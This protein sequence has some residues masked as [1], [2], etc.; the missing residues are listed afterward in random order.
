MIHENAF[1]SQPARVLDLPAVGTVPDLLTA[2]GIEPGLHPLAYVSL[3]GEPVAFEHGHRVRPKDGTQMDVVL[4]LAG[5]LQGL[6]MLVGN[7]TL[8][9]AFSLVANIGGALLGQYVG[10][11]GGALLGAGVSVGGVLAINALIPPPVEEFLNTASVTGSQS[12]MRVY[13]PVPVLFGESRL[14]PPLA[15]QAYTEVGDKNEQYLRLVYVLG[16][17][18]LHVE[19]FRIGDTPIKDYVGRGNVEGPFIEVTGGE[20]TRRTFLDEAPGWEILPPPTAFNLN[21]TVN[22]RSL[23]VALEHGDES[24]G[25]WYTQVAPA[26]QE[27]PEDA[28]YYENVRIGITSGERATGAE[29]AVDITFPNGLYWGDQDN[30]TPQTVTFEIQYR[31]AGSGDDDESGGWM[32]VTFT[33]EANL[34]L[35]NHAQQTPDQWPNW[36][37]ELTSR[38]EERLAAVQAIASVNRRA[39]SGWIATFKRSLLRA[40]D[41]ARDLR[42]RYEDED[43]EPAIQGL[44]NVLQNWFTESSTK[45]L[46][47]W[48]SRWAAFD[49]HVNW[50]ATVVESVNALTDVIAYLQQPGIDPIDLADYPMF[51]SFWLNRQNR[52]NQ[53]DLPEE[54]EFWV[55]DAY[56]GTVRRTVRWYVTPGQ[57]EVR[58]RRVTPDYDDDSPVVD[59]AQ[60]TALRSIRHI[61]PV[62]EDGLVIAHVRIKA[63][64]QL[65]GMVDRLNCLAR[66]YVPVWTDGASAYTDWP[67]SYAQARNPAWQYLSRICDPRLAKRPM[68]L[69]RVD[70]DAIKDWAAACVA[71]T[72]LGPSG[73]VCDLVIDR[74]STTF[75][76]LKTIASVGRAAF[77]MSDTGR[78]SVLR[79][80]AQTDVVQHFSPRNSWGFTSQKHFADETHGL[81]LRF[82]NSESDY[83]EDEI[84]VYN[85]K[86]D[87]TYWSEA[88]ATI[89]EEMQFPGYPTAKQA[90][91]D[92]RF[93]LGAFRLRPERFAFETDVEHLACGRGSLIRVAHDVPM[94]GLG[95]GRVKSVG[96]GALS[97]VLDEPMPMELAKNYAVRFRL[98]TSGAT[99]GDTIVCNVVSLS[100]S[101]T[102]GFYDEID[103]E[104]AATGVAPGD[105]F[106]F[107][108]RGTESVELIV[109]E[110]QPGDGLTS[111]LICIDHAPEL[112][113]EDLLDLPDY[114]PQ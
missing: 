25:K 14:Y 29:L 20:R 65:S 58:V 70:V 43:E 76:V 82:M 38:L 57:Y 22:E 95:Y 85:K 2:S 107:G 90:Y 53:F 99:A 5:P 63:D 72:D 23:S 28:A 44:I 100:D 7:D 67:W 86:P 30:K 87:G 31:I 89:F 19:D 52:L 77:A 46:T 6:G 47:A 66:A 9:L 35:T 109:L 112:Y 24:E 84:V 69:S 108:E 17:W 49:I 13:E 96:P 26:I 104:T 80:M 105:L 56:A 21:E 1:N 113:D 114:D 102:E 60:W 27:F 110:V 88:D 41:R 15:A 4:A 48:E 83:Q 78:Y 39:E 103:L 64:E 51:I 106:L 81:K 61:K 91:K 79:D 93:H 92:G 16:H 68:P 33:G 101:G 40:L 32:P 73:R 59:D 12:A 10:G 11:A 18:P 71:E 45:W 75:E 8:R 74:D 97:V 37:E 34:D 94:W 98:G 55:R 54:H 42:S 62:K 3:N 50:A 111:K 36:I